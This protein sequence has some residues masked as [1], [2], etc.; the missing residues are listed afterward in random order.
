MALLGLQ[1]AYLNNA[2]GLIWFYSVQSERIINDYLYFLY[3]G[4]K[5]PLHTY[6]AYVKETKF[7]FDYIQKIEYI[8][9]KIIIYLGVQ[10][11]L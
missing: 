1:M 8:I 2:F 11:H 5:C 10:Y 6:D 4:Q 7:D 9:I 3:I